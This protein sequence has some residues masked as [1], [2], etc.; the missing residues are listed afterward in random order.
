MYQC[1]T[2]KEKRAT[3]RGLFFHYLIDHKEPK[4]RAYDLAGYDMSNSPGGKSYKSAIRQVELHNCEKVDVS[5]SGQALE[6]E[7]KRLASR[8]KYG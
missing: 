6:E 5:Y 3:G 1:S 2:C 7:R 8:E 4:E